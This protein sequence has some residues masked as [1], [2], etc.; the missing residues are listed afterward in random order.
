VYFKNIL[1]CGTQKSSSMAA[2]PWIITVDAISAIPIWKKKT[3]NK[4]TCCSAGWVLK[5][6]R[7][8]NLQNVQ[9]SMNPYFILHILSKRICA[10]ILH[11]RA[12]MN[13]DL[14]HSIARSCF[15]LLNRALPYNWLENSSLITTL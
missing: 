12:T 3:W 10:N 6:M 1:K 4:S 13:R 7:V 9:L 2:T 15:S 5:N 8:W 11:T 14:T